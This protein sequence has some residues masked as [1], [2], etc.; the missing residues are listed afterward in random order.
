[1]LNIHY[2]V[3]H[4]H[5]HKAI[6]KNN[7]SNSGDLKTHKSGKNWTSQILSENL[8]L[9]SDNRVKEVKNFKE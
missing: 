8:L 1:M 5:M 3:T 4:T 6:S 7:F 9:V 2:P